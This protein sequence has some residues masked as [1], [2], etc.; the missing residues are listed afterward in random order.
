MARRMPLIAQTRAALASGAPLAVI[1]WA[2]AA[3]AL[4]L[5]AGTGAWAAGFTASGEVLGFLPDPA[6]AA[7][8]SGCGVAE[9][10]AA[11]ALAHAA[12]L[13]V[14]AV[15]VAYLVLREG[16][17]SGAAAVSFARGTR[18]GAWLARSAAIASAGV[19]VPFAAMSLVAACAL[20]AASAAAPV[21]VAAE[22][23]PR[24][25]VATLVAASL[26][27]LSMAAFALLGVG[28]V[29]ATAVIVLAVA[30]LVAQMSGAP[31]PTHTGA[32]AVACGIGIVSQLPA[33]ALFAAAT[34]AAEL[35]VAFV[36]IRKR[37]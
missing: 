36:A 24:L 34:A 5:L 15:A 32:L 37:V 6:Y 14:A 18:R 7:G 13:P 19:A 29:A 4:Y 31:V 33:Q 35:A 8:V 22:L 30:G 9:A 11:A 2:A 28:P 17:S 23:L 27:C 1:V 20:G 10:V 12:V 26:S 3:A 21:A 25:A 16:L